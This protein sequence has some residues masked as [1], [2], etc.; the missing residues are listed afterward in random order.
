MKTNYYKVKTISFSKSFFMISIIIISAILGLGIRE[1]S[2]QISKIKSQTSIKTEST[3]NRLIQTLSSPFWN[4]EFKRMKNIIKAELLSEKLIESISIQETDIDNNLQT[5]ICISRGV[6]DQFTNC[7]KKSFSQNL[8]KNKD[9]MRKGKQIGQ[10]TIYF[11]QTFI[12][13]QKQKA[14]IDIT[15]KLALLVTIIIGGLYM[16]A[17]SL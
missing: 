10:V 13:N 16:A 4:L 6:S 15:M 14:L 11:S 2:N 5:I 8:K 12:D 7:Q 3:L 9:I 1:Y 17:R